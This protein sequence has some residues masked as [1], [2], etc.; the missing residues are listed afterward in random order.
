MSKDQMPQSEIPNKSGSSPIL[1]GA[2]VAILGV[3]LGAGL[4]AFFNGNG[5]PGPALVQSAAATSTCSIDKADQEKLNASA[6]GEI[7]A[8]NALDRPYS[9]KDFTFNNRKGE[10]LTFAD[11]QGR[12]AL[13]NLWATWCAP[14][15]AEMP[16]LDA[17]NKELGGPEFEVVAISVDLGEPGRP[18]GFFEEIGLQNLGFYHDPKLDTLNA[19]KREGLAFGLPATLLIGKDG[20]VLG[21]LNGPAEW[22]GEDAKRLIKTALEL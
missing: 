16:A 21:T 9:V 3:A 19:L 5:K 4:Y 22:A 18:I 7:A 13:L 15:R 12:T 1:I 17:L 6:T 8:F 14:C 10:A 20:C 11:W 2:V